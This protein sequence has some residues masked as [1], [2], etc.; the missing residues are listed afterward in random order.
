MAF[1]KSSRGTESHKN[2]MW[3]EASKT[4]LEARVLPKAKQWTEP[5]HGRI[6][7]IPLKFQSNLFWNEPTSSSRGLWEILLFLHDIDAFHA[8]PSVKSLNHFQVYE[9]L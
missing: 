9:S 2:S 1:L 4:F 8:L 6:V 5:D 3:D 7:A